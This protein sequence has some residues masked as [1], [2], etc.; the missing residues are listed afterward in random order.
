MYYKCEQNEFPCQDP[1]YS[2]FDAV[3]IRELQNP[4]SC[5]DLINQSPYC[6][7]LPIDNDFVIGDLNHKLYLKGLNRKSG[8]YHL[9]SHF[10]ECDD[11]GTYSML[12]VYVGKGF[13]EGRI[14]SHIKNKWPS[15]NLEMYVSFTEMPNRLSKYYEQLFLDKYNFLLNI[16]ENSGSENLYAVWDEERFVIGTEALNVSSLSKVTSPDDF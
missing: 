12:C 2:T 16:S 7:H 9:W 15:P 1:D 8:L 13:A 14:D 5:S 10:D 3:A 6:T 11:H 4:V